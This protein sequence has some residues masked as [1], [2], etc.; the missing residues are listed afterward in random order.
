MSE[1]L[2]PAGDR[3]AFFAALH[4][5]A[6]AVYLGLTD[7]SARKAASNFSLEN[8]NEYTAYAH[9]LGAKVYVALNT[10]IKQGE[11][12]AFFESARAAWN[13]GADALILQD[14]FLG[15]MLKRAYPE[16]VLHLST[17]AGVCNVYGARLAKRLGFDRAILARET[18]LKDMAAI[19]SVIETEV[20]V[21]GALCTCFSG[22]CEF[23][24][25]AG[26]NSGNRGRCKQPCRKK[27]RL[28]RRGFEEYSYKLSLSDLSMGK[29]VA[30]LQRAG[31]SSF[32]IE[33]RLR[34][35]AYVGS[36]VDYYRR[37]LSGEESEGAFSDLK[38]AFNRGNYTK[39]Y[40]YGQ[41]RD[42]ISSDVQGHVGECVGRIARI[43]RGKTV[44][45]SVRS[46]FHPEKGDGFKILRDGREIG[47]A[48]YSGGADAVGFT[49]SVPP[50]C[51]E[52]DEVC[53]T[54]DNSLAR[55]V[56][57]RRRLVPVRVRVFAEEG[58]RPRAVVQT[59]RGKFEFTADF[60]AER[61]LSRALT[62]E[63]I[64]ECFSKTDLYPFEIS[65]DEIAVHGRPFAVR[66]MLNAF[67]RE[68]YAQTARRLSGVRNPLA[69]REVF[70]KTDAD[71]GSSGGAENAGE[72]SVRTAVI[73]SD[74]S[75]ELYRTAK[76]DCAVFAPKDYKD[77]G[78][79]RVFSEIADKNG[80]K[81]Y[82]Y[83]PAYTLA[84]DFAAIGACLPFFDGVY[85]EGVFALEYCREKGV[86]CFA[87]T[88]M[89]AFNGADLLSLR[90]EG[91]SAV[92]LSEELSFSETKNLAGAYV[93]AGGSVR[94]MDL[95][96]CPFGRSCASCD[97]RARYT[98]TDEKGR[99]FPLVRY[100]NSVCR[101][102]VF[103]CAPLAAEYA[104]GRRLFDFRTLTEKQKAAYLSAKDVKE[105][106]AALGTYTAGV[107]AT[108]V[109]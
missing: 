60:V 8:L 88:G 71:A 57:E 18:P 73:D 102:Q 68:A 35:A 82:L 89:N 4:S 52:G 41:D 74:F 34:S 80:W 92:C 109:L 62:E 61:A 31:V 32:K 66:S 76:I 12:S 33:G 29:E 40:L 47:G 24:A 100:E 99:A 13:A 20:F 1:I 43:R 63:E 101:F 2:A 96:H 105:L 84:D 83:L 16:M 87:G 5:G 51:R 30:A 46:D 55:R 106:K 15:G 39:G 36:A 10:L 23:S 27:Y 103:N 104:G 45:A 44:L 22:Q 107:S 86:P 70:A 58:E 81:K 85:G 94:L 53:L 90:R 69:P 67:R 48:Q 28:D 98:L 64:K 3:E 50:A 38:R 65:F 97:R 59:P 6:D 7:F 25:Y 49:L 11:L 26:G 95:G 9:M 54:S 37:L 19:S 17:Q 77:I 91:A 42:L 72:V 78:K 14:V 79:I 93:F 21:Q 56:A 108:G 75:S